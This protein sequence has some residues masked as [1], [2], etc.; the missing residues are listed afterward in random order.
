MIRNHLFIFCDV[1]RQR[2]ISKSLPGVWDGDRT[3]KKGFPVF[4]TGTGKSKSIPAFLGWEREIQKKL[5][6]CFRMRKPCILIRKY[7]GTRNP[8]HACSEGLSQNLFFWVNLANKNANINCILTYIT[9]SL[10]CQGLAHPPVSRVHPHLPYL[11][12]YGWM[13][14]QRVRWRDSRTW[15]SSNRPI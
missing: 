9:S 4:R 8:A 14:H 3:V 10:F 5:S 6:R 7:S 11:L 1:G 15:L 13:I 2:K 12:M